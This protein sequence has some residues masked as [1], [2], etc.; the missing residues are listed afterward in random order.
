[1]EQFATHKIG[2]FD[3]LF[4]LKPLD[5]VI[6]MQG[7]EAARADAISNRFTANP[8]AKRTVEHRSWK[9]GYDKADDS[10]YVW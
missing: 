3:R 7:A 10:T 2:L 1:M 6:V 9:S 8:Y 4:R 5:P